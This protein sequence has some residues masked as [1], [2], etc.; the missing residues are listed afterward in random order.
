MTL[1]SHDPNVIH[2]LEVMME[3]NFIDKENLI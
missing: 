3:E 2:L 1:L